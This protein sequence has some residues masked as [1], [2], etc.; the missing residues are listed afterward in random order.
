MAPIQPAPPHDVRGDGS[1]AGGSREKQYASIVPDENRLRLETTASNVSHQDM[2]DV[3][4]T[5]TGDDD[6]IYNRFPERRK[7]IITA[8]LSYCSFLAPISST[9]VL[10]A[11]PEV[12]ETYGCDGSIINLSN[13]MYMLFMGLSPCFY[14]PF[15]NIY[16]RRWVRYAL[17]SIET[18]SPLRGTM[19]DVNEAVL[20]FVCRSLLSVQYCSSDSQSALP[21][22]P[23][24]RPFSSS[25]S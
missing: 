24:L 7:L 2:P 3:Q 23:T 6:E 20:T 10:S 5:V 21:L 25:V 13:A 22:R 11:V 17:T 16:G 4:Y 14:G 1:G 19:R 15:G 12:A 8:V 18:V 9:T